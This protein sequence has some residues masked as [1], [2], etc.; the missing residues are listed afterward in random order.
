MMKEILNLSKNSLAVLKVLKQLQDK[1]ETMER[2]ARILRLNHGELSE[3][4]RA[5]EARGYKI[6]V[7]GDCSV[8]LLQ[9]P[10]TL[11]PWDVEDG[12]STHRMGR[13]TRVFE[14][15]D[16][17]NAFAAQWA[18]E[19]APD[20]AV[21]AAE[22]QTSGRGRFDRQWASPAEKG[23]YFS[24]ILRPDLPMAQVPMLTFLTAAAV[25]ETLATATGIDA[26]VKWP[27]DVLVKGRKICGILA[28]ARPAKTGRK[29]EYAVIGVG[30]NV[31]HE[32][33]DFPPDCLT[34]ATSVHLETGYKIF[35]AGLLQKIL[36]VMEYYYEQYR[37]EGFPWLYKVWMKRNCTMG[38]LVKINTNTEGIVEGITEGLSEQGGLLLR[39]SDGTL[40]EFL[41]GDVSIGSANFR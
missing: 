6:V 30:L 33:N 38:R 26:Q 41:A 31:N 8:R 35:R 36:E 2:I 7:D 17:T 1:P 21:A 19:G 23:L 4:L 18:H 16:S 37:H 12:I 25:A 24:L 3:A 20:G 40:R 10:E 22:M 34:A 28:E 39:T 9:S 32:M 29:A 11:F 27:N 14:Q 5:L 15:I 13:V